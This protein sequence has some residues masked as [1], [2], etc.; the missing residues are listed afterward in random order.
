MYLFFDIDDTLL[1]SSR[2]EHLAACDWAE[3]HPEVFGDDPRAFAAAWRSISVDY[4]RRWVRGELSFIEQ[5]RARIRYYWPTADDAQADA[6]FAEYLAHYRQ[7]WSLF[8]DTQPALGLLADYCKGVITNGEPSQ[9]S[10]K[11]RTFGLGRF[12]RW[13]VTPASA[14]YRKPQAGIFDVAA[15]L[16]GAKATDCCYVGDLPNDD[17]RAARN[18]GWRSIWLNRRGDPPAKDIET[19]TTLVELPALLGVRAR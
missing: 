19:I 3:R 2:A 1:D 13:L 12:F 18:A 11:L 9:Q 16:A 14:G 4:Y 6:H 17:A 15:A 8:A 5:R 7:H 10:D